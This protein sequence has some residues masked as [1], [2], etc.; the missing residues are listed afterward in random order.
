MWLKQKFTP[1]RKTNTSVQCLQRTQNPMFHTIVLGSVEPL[2]LPAPPLGSGP[3][4]QQPPWNGSW[5][6]LGFLL[7]M[8]LMC[9]YMVA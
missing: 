8:V 5:T 4:R 9:R 6:L 2:P 1:H 3:G 7:G